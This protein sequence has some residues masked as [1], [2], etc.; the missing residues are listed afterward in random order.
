MISILIMQL[1]DASFILRL[2]SLVLLNSEV[3]MIAVSICLLEV[4]SCSQLGQLTW[5]IRSNKQCS[6]RQI[7]PICLKISPD[8]D[9][10]EYFK[11]YDLALWR[12]L[13]IWACERLSIHEALHNVVWEMVIGHC[14]GHL[15]R[16]NQRRHPR[17]NI[18]FTMQ[19]VTS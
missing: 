6:S 16:L 11:Q 2:K 15:F 14:N 18:P 13:F 7:P 17:S 9:R 8:M 12:C 10:I 1:G 4:I 5:V 3:G 19:N